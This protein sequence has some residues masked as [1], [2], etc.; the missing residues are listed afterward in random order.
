MAVKARD[1]NTALGGGVLIGMGV[2]V[3]LMDTTEDDQLG[4]KGNE[5][6]T[7]IAASTFT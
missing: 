7:N 1:T 2:T 5:E 3:T 4:V 6:G